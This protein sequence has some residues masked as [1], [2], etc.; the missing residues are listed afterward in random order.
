MQETYQSRLNARL[1][2]SLAAKHGASRCEDELRANLRG[3]FKRVSPVVLQVAA[4]HS[5]STSI[6]ATRPDEPDLELPADNTDP[7][8]VLMAIQDEAREIAE[9]TAE[10]ERRLG[11]FEHEE[12][13]RNRARAEL[14]RRFA[15]DRSAGPRAALRH[16]AGMTPSQIAAQDGV[17]ENTVNQRLSRFVRD[18]DEETRALLAPLRLSVPNPAKGRRRSSD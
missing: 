2:D 1:I 6:H 9:L 8:E 13:L 18:L 14:R 16:A 12:R 5:T 4:A 3:Y 15:A 17:R 10:Q 11:A 7:Y